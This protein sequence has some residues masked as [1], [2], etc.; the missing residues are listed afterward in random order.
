MP[1]IFNTMKLIVYFLNAYIY[2]LVAEVL[3]LWWD[4]FFVWCADGKNKIGLA[5]IK[6]R[7]GNSCF[8]RRIQLVS[9]TGDLLKNT[10][11][12]VR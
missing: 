12:G 6:N 4:Y 3:S 9:A 5:K 2:Q 8:L 10:S 7:E 1:T 11:L